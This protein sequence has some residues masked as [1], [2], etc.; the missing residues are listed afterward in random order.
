M[1]QSYITAEIKMKTVSY[2]VE[3]W[4]KPTS[5]SKRLVIMAT[6]GERKSNF[7]EKST[8]S[9]LQIENENHAA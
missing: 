2:I 1:Y 7:I 8:L 9:I 4:I 3:I 6:N 5:S